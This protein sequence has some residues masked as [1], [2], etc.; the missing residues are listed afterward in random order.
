MQKSA[1]FNEKRGFVEK[2]AFGFISAFSVN[3]AKWSNSEKI[4]LPTKPIRPYRRV[5]R[6]EKTVS[7]R[8]API[9]ILNGEM[10]C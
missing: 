7:V 2:L 8:N 4:F 1:N 9:G 6:W 5:L 3:V 10:G